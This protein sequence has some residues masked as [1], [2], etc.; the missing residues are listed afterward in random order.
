MADLGM[1]RV[2]DRKRPREYRYPMR[3][4]TQEIL[5]RIKDYM[6]SMSTKAEIKW[7]LKDTCGKIGN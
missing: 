1:K 3:N 7:L 4:R 6:K 2:R 5:K